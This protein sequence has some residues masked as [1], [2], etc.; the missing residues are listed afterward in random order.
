M[1]IRHATIKD[2]PAMGHVMVETYMSSHKKHLPQKAWQ[3]RTKKWTPEVSAR[4]WANTLYQIEET[5]NAGKKPDDCLYVAL[6][7][8]VSEHDGIIGLVMGHPGESDGVAV[9]GS[10]YVRQSHHG[11]GIGRRLVQTVAEHMVNLGF[12]ILQI[13]VLAANK[14]AR[15]FYEAIG[16]QVIAE[17]EFDEEG[18]LLPEAVYE[19]S[20]IQRLVKG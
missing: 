16:G 15:R 1:L 5:I 20:D 6:D 3:K 9:I 13:G 11:Q 14:P 17:R 12:T 2:A 19:W 8:Q 4:G 18:I 10:L 7:E